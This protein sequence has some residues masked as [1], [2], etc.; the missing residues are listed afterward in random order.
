M[1]QIQ[2]L[3]GW[4]EKTKS[5][6]QTQSSSNAFSWFPLNKSLNLSQ[7]QAFTS[8]S[9]SSVKI[10]YITV[11]VSLGLWVIAEVPMP[12]LE[13]CLQ[14]AQHEELLTELKEC[15]SQEDFHHKG[16]KFQLKL[17]SKWRNTVDNLT[18]KTQKVGNDQA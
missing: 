3:G 8:S 9:Q 5:V 6:R 15:V 12:T 14:Q 11:L 17:C 18:E 4:N 16:Q 7:H 13:P 2:F 10:N 1:Q